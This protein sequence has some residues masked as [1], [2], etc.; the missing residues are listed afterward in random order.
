MRKTDRR[1]LWI[2]AV[3]GMAGALGLGLGN[4]T[5]FGA[6]PEIDSLAGIHQVIR[7]LSSPHNHA[8]ERTQFPLTIN[9]SQ[10]P[11]SSSNLNRPSEGHGYLQSE[12]DPSKRIVYEQT[13]QPKDSSRQDKLSVY[14][15]LQETCQRWTRWYNKDRSSH[16]A[17]QMNVACREAAEYGRTE[18]NI[19]TKARQ[20]NVKSV[21]DKST[22]P[23]GGAIL[24]ENGGS[25]GSPRCQE[26]RRQLDHI[27]SRLRAGYKVQE[28]ERLKKRRREIRDEIQQRC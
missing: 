21:K 26:L 16:S 3:L 23:G 4:T 5:G 25:S 24:I 18:L 9:A 14:R 19:N 1:R 10:R 17:V 8:R 20:V 2:M 7:A 6:G 12:V 15:S 28:G 22:S 13:Q 27:Q 11:A